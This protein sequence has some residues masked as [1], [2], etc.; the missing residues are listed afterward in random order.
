MERKEYVKEVELTLDELVE[1]KKMIAEL[2]ESREREL[3]FNAFRYGAKKDS[4][5]GEEYYEKIGK[6]RKIRNLIDYLLLLAENK[7]N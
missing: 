3:I 5:I 7:D 2:L 1:D 6:I 4:K